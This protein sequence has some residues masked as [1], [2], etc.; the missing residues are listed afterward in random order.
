MDV[1]AR[2]QKDTMTEDQFRQ[3]ADHLQRLGIKIIE[4]LVD[5]TVAI[6][7]LDGRIGRL[8]GKIE[9]LESRVEAKVDQGVVFR[10][11]FLVNSAFFAVLGVAALALRTFGIV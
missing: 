8:E 5:N 11:V 1:G 7:N 4:G 2:A 9:G 3:I 10:T 6:A